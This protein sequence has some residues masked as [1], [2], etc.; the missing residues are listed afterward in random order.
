[1]H[2]RV[3]AMVH[4]LE[5]PRPFY[6]TA[7]FITENILIPTPCFALYNLSNVK[8]THY[9]HYLQ[10]L[11]VLFVS[12]SWVCCRVLGLFQTFHAH[13]TILNAHPTIFCFRVLGLF[14]SFGFVSNIPRT[15]HDAQRPPYDFLF[16]YFEF[17][18]EFWVRF[19]DST[20]TPRCS[21]PTPL[22]SLRK[23]RK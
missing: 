10:Y 5:F 1:M 13:S 18:V 17:V 22:F 12:E 9:F 6:C 20:H 2:A 8:R 4:A 21:T 15:H 14:A 23:T 16:P 11:F 3:A 7:L 19:K